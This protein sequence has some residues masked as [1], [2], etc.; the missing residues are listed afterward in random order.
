VGIQEFFF[1]FKLI[2]SQKH[3][4]YTYIQVDKLSRKCLYSSS[5]AAESDVADSD[6]AESDEGG[7]M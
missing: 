6:L 4:L 2:Y 7:K 5:D 3:I 1:R